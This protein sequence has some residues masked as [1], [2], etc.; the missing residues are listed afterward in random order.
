LTGVAVDSNGIF[1]FRRDTKGNYLQTLDYTYSVITNT[2]TLVTPITLAEEI[3]IKYMIAGS[4][5]VAGLNNEAYVEEFVATPGQTVFTLAHNALGSAWV[6]VSGR[7]GLY[8]KQGGTRDYTLSATDEITLTSP[9]ESGDIITVQYISDVLTLEKATTPEA[10]A[11]IEDTHYM[12]PSKTL[13]AILGNRDPLGQTI[14]TDITSTT[15][16]GIPTKPKLVF[17]NG[18][19]MTDTV[20][21]TYAGTTLTF[22]IATS[23]TDTM[24]IIY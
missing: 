1:V 4:L 16:A 9:A 6:R 22:T 20:D 5:V 14:I 8:E 15:Y 18:L 3:L 7:S 21:Y 13:D 23:G 10:I 17:K 11:G 19:F 24:T 2:V 12:T